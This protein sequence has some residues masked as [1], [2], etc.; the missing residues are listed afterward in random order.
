MD[1]KYEVEL[2]KIRYEVE[3][4]GWSNQRKNISKRIPLKE[5]FSRIYH[6]TDTKLF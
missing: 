6:E 3:S 2:I 4:R 5:R 1:D